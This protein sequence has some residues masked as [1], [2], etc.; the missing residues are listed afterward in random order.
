MTKPP[1]SPTYTRLPQVDLNFL[2]G[3]LDQHG[4]MDCLA[5]VAD[6]VTQRGY[7]SADFALILGAAIGEAAKVEHKRMPTYIVQVVKT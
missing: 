1:I 7:G 3:L 6:Y 5:A 2:S 4:V